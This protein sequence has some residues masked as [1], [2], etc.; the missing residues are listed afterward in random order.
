VFCDLAE[1]VLISF[2]SFL[3]MILF[4]EVIYLPGSPADGVRAAMILYDGAPVELIAF[5]NRTQE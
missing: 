2:Q 5:K 1:L 3:E 4:G